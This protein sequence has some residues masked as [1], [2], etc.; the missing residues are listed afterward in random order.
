[1]DIIARERRFSS[2]KPCIILSQFSGRALKILVA[3]QQVEKESHNC[4]FLH[5]HDSSP[6][7]SRVRLDAWPLFVHGLHGLN[8]SHLI[9]SMSTR[10]SLGELSESGAFEDD[11]C[12][13]LER[14]DCDI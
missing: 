10:Y 4:S 2:I 3:N 13:S 9:L 14:R 7:A 5:S 1:L 8:L 12:S 6:I 11:G